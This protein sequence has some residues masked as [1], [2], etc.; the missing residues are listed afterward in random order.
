MSWKVGKKWNLVKKI[1]WNWFFWLHEF[2]F[3]AWTI[4]N[5][6]AHCEFHEK[7]NKYLFFKPLPNVKKAKRRTKRLQKR[8]NCQEL[9]GSQMRNLIW[10]QIWTKIIENIWTD[11]ITKF[12][13]ES[14]CLVWF[15]MKFLVLLYWTNCKMV[16]DLLSS[17][18]KKYI[19]PKYLFLISFGCRT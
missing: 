12:F 5:F 9:S 13:C 8:D 11:T 4:L 2:F 6:L 10:K 14:K 3:L 16:L 17:K 7:N 1:P 19:A 18:L 15:N